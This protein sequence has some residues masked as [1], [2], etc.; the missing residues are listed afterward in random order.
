MKVYV[1]RVQRGLV[2]TAAQKH[3]LRRASGVP[4]Q[5]KVFVLL[6]LHNPAETEELS[7][8]HLT[9]SGAHVQGRGVPRV[10]HSH[11]ETV[12]RRH[13]KRTINGVL[14]W[15]KEYVRQVLH[16]NAVTVDS[17]SATRPASG[18][19]ARA[20]VF[21]RQTLPNLVQGT[22]V[23][24]AHKHALNPVIGELVLLRPVQL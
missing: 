5:D 23:A 7:A 2:E 4:V 17:R 8:A 18:A 16:S 15:A 3:A 13:V 9:A 12:G 22:P 21:A 24:V 14:A 6:I 11:V 1:H 10:L 20:K 19:H